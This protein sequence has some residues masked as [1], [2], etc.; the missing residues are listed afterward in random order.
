M[1][2]DG[3]RR[4]MGAWEAFLSTC[5]HGVETLAVSGDNRKIQNGVG[6]GTQTQ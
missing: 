1:A 2:Q 6:G 4:E 3:S 5:L